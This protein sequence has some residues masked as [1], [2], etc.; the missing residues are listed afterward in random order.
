MLLAQ[1]ALIKM[2][3]E[4]IAAGKSVRFT[5][6]PLVKGKDKVKLTYKDTLEEHQK[7]EP[8]PE[9]ERE[10]MQMYSRRL[11]EWKVSKSMRRSRRLFGLYKK[12]YLLTIWGVGPAFFSMYP[13]IP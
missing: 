8:K 4:Y 1:W 11:G 10:I 12:V 2:I 13:E 5:A 6:V 9:D 7:V 3:D